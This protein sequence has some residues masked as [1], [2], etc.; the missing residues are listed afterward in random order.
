MFKNP[1]SFSGRIRRLE[2]GMTYV[3][4]FAF[5]MCISILNGD[6]PEEGKATPF[7]I[8][9]VPI[10]WFYWAQAA[11]RC[12]DRGNSGWFQL[13]PF[14]PL[15]MLFGDS[16]YGPNEYGPNPKGLGNNDTNDI[17]NHLV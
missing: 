10:V 12:H 4:I 13:I 17:S 14:Y 15:F 6:N 2:F 8:A 1:F 7:L 5:A 11:K 9:F 16:M 3:I